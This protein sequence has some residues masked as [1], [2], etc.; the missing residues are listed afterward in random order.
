[1]W[2]SNGV[3]ERMEFN[4]GFTKTIISLIVLSQGKVLTNMFDK[5]NKQKNLLK[6]LKTKRKLVIEIFLLQ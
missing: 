4:K 3:T 6:K 1:M 2:F 5:I